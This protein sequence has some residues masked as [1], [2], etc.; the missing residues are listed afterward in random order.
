M[1]AM[2]ALR[3]PVSLCDA[4]AVLAS[5]FVTVPQAAIELLHQQQQW[6]PDHELQPTGLAPLRKRVGASR[7]RPFESGAVP[8][9]AVI[10]VAPADLSL[11]VAPEAPHRAHHDPSS[12]GRPAISG[13][14][15]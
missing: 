12:V 15:S 5:G 14:Q 13:N 2:Q 7:P 8:R 9:L 11:A 3:V 6:D 4:R 1:V 10:A